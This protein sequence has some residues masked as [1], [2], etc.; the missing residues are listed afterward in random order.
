MANDGLVSFRDFV[1]NKLDDSVSL[2]LAVARY[3]ELKKKVA[4]EK[5]AQ[6]RLVKEKVWERVKGARLVFDLYHPL[7]A[8]RLYDHRVLR[9]L[10]NASAFIKDMQQ[11]RFR[12]LSLRAPPATEASQRRR[13]TAGHLAAPHFAFDANI[14]A[15]VVEAVPATVSVW[16]IVDTLQESPMLVEFS[17]TK[18]TKEALSRHLRMRFASSA[19]VEEALKVLSGDAALG[20][21]S[22]RP[23]SL[24][25]RQT[26]EALVV[27][28][29][30][31]QPERLGEDL[32]LSAQVVRKLDTL[33]LIPQEITEA[34]LGAEAA[35]VEAKL[36]LQV[37][38]LRRVHY[39]CYY[40]ASWCEDEWE[41][42]R[43]CGP[44]V[45]RPAL[46]AARIPAESIGEAAGDKWSAAHSQRLKRFL[47]KVR[48]D[49]PTALSTDEE[50]LRSQC[51][52]LCEESVKQMAEGKFQCTRCSKFFRGPEFII[53]HVRK[54]HTDL[55]E[56]LRQGAHA[57]AALAAFLAE[58]P[59]SLAAAIDA[60]ALASAP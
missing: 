23:A 45:L 26:L 15:V 17:V 29:V 24:Q 1:L 2:E 46:D 39:F 19:D 7:S 58:E 37:L 53:K 31:S 54:M 6:I 56:A 32:A 3:E 49:R 59:S 51:K 27:P 55:L 25:A 10:S 34:M 52:A 28:P 42:M 40:A 20:A 60:E 36:D 9:A 16:D 35:S 8:M 38:Y 22:L 41:L 44:A 4:E 50:P 48:F 47:G 30:M 21:A 14:N 33:M 11:G 5:A 13:P 57:E 43:R 18:P 12:E